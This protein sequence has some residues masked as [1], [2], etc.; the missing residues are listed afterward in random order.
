MYSFSVLFAL[1]L[2]SLTFESSTSFTIIPQQQRSFTILASTKSGKK[3][4]PS[5]IID[6]DGPTQEFNPLSVEEVDSEDVDVLRQINSD[7]DLPRPIPHQPWRRGDT[8]G[9]EAPIAAPWR[10]QAESIITNAVRFIGGRVIDVTWYLTSVVVTLDPY[11]TDALPKDLLKSRGPPI[12]VM[13]PSMPM[14]YDPEDPSP[15]DIIGADE[16]VGIMEEEEPEETHYR[17]RWDPSK[18]IEK[19]K[20]G[21]T[22]EEKAE[23]DPFYREK[24]KVP[25]TRADIAYQAAEE[26]AERAEEASTPVDPDSAW[27]FEPVNSR[28]NYDESNFEDCETEPEI[29]TS[30]LSTI[31]GAIIDALEDYEEELR[32]LE[33][34]ELILTSPSYDDS[35]L[36]TQKQFDAHRGQNVIVE[37]QDPFNSNRVLK[38]K[39]LDRNSMDVLINK[40]GRMVTIPLNFVK[41]V[42]KGPSKITE[43]QVEDDEFIEEESV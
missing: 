21:L 2:I 17:S 8:A 37:T 43:E 24:S 27:M 25:E 34:H 30:K 36:E 16:N 29:D 26:E 32:I 1:V 13:E 39:L 5:P 11:A 14:Y 38:G 20:V 42:R 12:N 28:M 40:Q 22:N 9:C 33:R 7:D 4:S 10:Q 31:A 6:P 23:F 15:V 19:M 3:R 41:C 35:T 18:M